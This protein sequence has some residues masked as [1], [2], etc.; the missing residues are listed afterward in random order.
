MSLIY[1][2]VSMSA[3]GKDSDELKTE[4]FQMLFSAEEL[5]EIDDVRFSERIGSRAET[6]R[7]LIKKG[8]E[9]F[10]KE[11]EEGAETETATKH[12]A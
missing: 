7:M 11:Q 4:R 9:A 3:R 2:E 10:A 8:R 1:S 5:R 12:Q 6:I